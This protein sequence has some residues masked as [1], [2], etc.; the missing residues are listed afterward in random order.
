MKPFIIRIISCKVKTYWYYDKVGKIFTCVGI[1]A[2]R[3]E[4]HIKITMRVK[5][6]RSYCLVDLDDFEVVGR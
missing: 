5:Y 3:Y 6:G 1:E 2:N 4:D